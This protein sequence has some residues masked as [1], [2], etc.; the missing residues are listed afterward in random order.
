MTIDPINRNGV[1]VLSNVSYLNKNQAN[2]GI[3]NTELLSTLQ[4][5]NK[6]NQNLLVS[7]LPDNKQI[8]SILIFDKIIRIFS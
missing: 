7:G 6:A 3:L 1:I 4:R 8:I 5:Q 2:I